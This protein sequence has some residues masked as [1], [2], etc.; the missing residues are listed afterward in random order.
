MYCKNGYQVR[1]HLTNVWLCI[2]SLSVNTSSK[3]NRL[4]NNYGTTTQISICRLNDKTQTK[5]SRQCPRLWGKN[6][7]LNNSKWIYI[8]LWQKKTHIIPFPTAGIKMLPDWTQIILLLISYK[9]IFALSYGLLYY[10]LI[11]YTIYYIV[12]LIDIIGSTRI[13]RMRLYFMYMYKIR[14]KNHI[15]TYNHDLR[16][17]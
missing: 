4:W 3:W 15:R 12:T 16:T 9:Y 17:K 1:E 10:P 8:N 6:A 13:V 5:A 11:L 14:A 7:C 2:I